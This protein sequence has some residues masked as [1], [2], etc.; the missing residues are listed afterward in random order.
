LFQQLKKLAGQ[1]AIYGIS[2]ILGKV[3]NFM[4]VPLHTAMLSRSEFGV[5]TDIYTIIAFL[6]VVLIYGLETSFFRFYEKYAEK[7]DTVYSTALIS[8]FVSTAFFLVVFAV[9]YSPITE[10]LKY[11]D[12]SRF[13]LWM[14]IILSLDI[15]AAIPFARLRA[16]NRGLRFVTVKLA[17]IVTNIIFNVLFFFPSWVNNQLPFE[18]IPYFFGSNLGVEYIFIANVFASVIMLLLLLPEKIGI[19]YTFDRVLWRKMLVFGI[20]LMVS[21][22]AGIA[23]E[24][25]DRQLLKYLLPEDIWQS[26]VGVYGAVYKLSIFLILFNQAFRYAA[27]PFF[28]S[29]ASQEKAKETFALVMTYF[30]M[31]MCLGFVLIMAYLDVFKHFIDSKFWEGLFIVPILLLANIFLGINTNLSFWYKL[32]DR[33]HQAIW[34]T[35]FGLVLTVIFNVWFIPIMGY[36]GAAWAT[37]ISYSGMMVLSY[38]LGQRYYPIPYDTKKIAVILT[39]ATILGYLAYRY[40]MLNFVP[41][42]LAF[43]AF[44]VVLILLE[45]KNIQ[46]LKERFASAKK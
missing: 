7:R 28:F 26:E 1:T 32:S 19:K 10:A 37:L 39:S 13:V 24:L 29:S 31:A 9:F 11:G 23:N 22:L 16:Q 38:W 44:L 4:L 27:E 14:M 20:P 5:N 46:K 36:E 40:A 42:T 3:L 33:T 18:V 34:I 30:V 21:G 45:R 41:Q 35:G 2:S 6:I 17:L 15:L 8:L 43:A 25:L 12:Q